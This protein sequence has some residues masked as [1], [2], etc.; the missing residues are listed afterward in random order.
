NSLYPEGTSAEIVIVTWESG[1]GD[2]ST[3]AP[4]VIRTIDGQDCTLL[5]SIVDPVNS[6]RGISTPALADLD[7]D[8][9]IEIIAR[10]NAGGVVAY[11]YNAAASAYEVMWAQTGGGP[12]V[13]SDLGQ[14][15]DGVAVHDINN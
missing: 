8:G 12:G 5:H 7:N 14:A 3:S 6:P 13:G 15:W 10:R 2:G 1:N 11:K 4:G 9:N